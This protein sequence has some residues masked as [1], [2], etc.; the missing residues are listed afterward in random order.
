MDSQQRRQ[1]RG[2][3]SKPG[4]I[5]LGVSMAAALVATAAGVSLVAP[6][7]LAFA[8]PTVTASHATAT[9]A[10][11]SASSASPLAAASSPSP[12]P[13]AT[14]SSSASP[15]PSPSASPSPTASPT[16][17]AAPN[18]TPDTTVIAPAG[19]ESNRVGALFSG[20][21]GPG[22]HFCTAS[23]VP[24]P[25]HNLILTAAHCLSS[26]Q[27]VSFVPG[28]RE[29][30][31]PFGSWPVT[32]IF[33][34]SGWS[35]NGD[36]DE[37]FAFLELGTNSSGQQVQDVVGAN[38]I[39]LNAAFT[40]SVRLYGYNNNGDDPSLCTNATSQF[41]TYQRQIACPAYAGGTSGGPWID[42]ST[43]AVI[44]VIG[45]YQQ[46]GDTPDVSYSAYFDQTIAGLYQTAES[47]SSS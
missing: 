39:G 23:V 46:G 25:S 9:H 5:L 20:S 26:T 13:S 34:T 18:L 42:T 24:S 21:V 4:P 47:Q 32:K 8:R 36:T 29:G 28:Y 3:R 45:G 37:D 43:G 7:A 11:P 33:T 12:S 30:N 16:P 41:S 19:P 14:P 40:D 10:S 2:R 22:N 17:V 6:E 44:G 35:Q 38:P 15:S 1:H 27:G 31:A